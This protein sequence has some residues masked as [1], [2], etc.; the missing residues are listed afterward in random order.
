M[1]KKSGESFDINKIN[2]LLKDTEFRQGYEEER[3]V[4]LF[5]EILSEIM[6]KRKWNKARLA[7]ELG[8]SKSYVTQLLKGSKNI[9]LRNLAKIMF[10]LGRR[11]NIEVAK[12][13]GS[14]EEELF[15]DDEY[16]GNVEL[17]LNFSI[18][19]KKQYSCRSLDEGKTNND[20]IPL[21]A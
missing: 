12:L 6:E 3:I 17:K 15:Q 10:R 9:S 11:V 2:E 19:K 5:G 16:K 13:S 1:K 20:A 18:N 4:I 8:F 21:A 7:R 14:F